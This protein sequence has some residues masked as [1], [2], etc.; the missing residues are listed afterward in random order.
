MIWLVL[1][2]LQK[3]HCTYDK[4]QNRTKLPPRSEVPVPY[5]LTPKVE[6]GIKVL[7]V[8]IFINLFGVAAYRLGL[9]NAPWLVWFLVANTMFIVM[10]SLVLMPGMILAVFGAL[11]LL[12]LIMAPLL[13]GTLY[14]LWHLPILGEALQGDPPEIWAVILTIVS[15]IALAVAMVP[16]YLWLEKKLVKKFFKR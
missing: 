13:F 14:L 15:V 16:V 1:N 6:K 11:I 3:L 4:K 7:G 9:D 10:L 12:L 8:A 5:A 2:P